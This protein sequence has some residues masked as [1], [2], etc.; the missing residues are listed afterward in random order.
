MTKRM[1]EL[2]HRLSCE[3]ESQPSC[4]S[5]TWW[6]IGGG[7]GGAAECD[8]DRRGKKS[9]KKERAT[10]ASSLNSRFHSCLQLR[11]E[12]NMTSEPSAFGRVKPLLQRNTQNV[13]SDW[14]P[15]LFPLF[16]CYGWHILSIDAIS[17]LSQLPLPTLHPTPPSYSIISSLSFPLF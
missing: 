16:C 1:N 6:N 13:W 10:A 12:L 5:L 8:T 17:T 14:L 11:T 9:Q 2:D 15:F 3:G 7:W 4:D